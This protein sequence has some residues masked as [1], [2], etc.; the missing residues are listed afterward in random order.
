MRTLAVIDHKLTPRIVQ[1]KSKGNCTYS[2]IR[3]KKLIVKTKWTM[4]GIIDTVTSIVPASLKPFSKSH[5][6][7]SSHP[8]PAS[9]DEPI[10]L[11][12][13]LDNTAAQDQSSSSTWKTS[14]VAAFFAKGTG[15]IGQ[16]M[17]NHIIEELDKAG[18][19]AN[20]PSGPEDA[21][22]RV[23]ARVLPFFRE[24]LEGRSV[25]MRLRRSAT[26]GSDEGPAVCEHT[27]GPSDNDGVSRDE[28]SLQGAFD[29]GAIA[30]AKC[31]GGVN[32]VPSYTTFAAPE[33]WA[34]ISDIDDTI[35]VTL[36]DHV[37]GALKTTF[38]DDPTPIKG[39]PE[40]YWHMNTALNNPPFWYLSA[41]PYNLYPFLHDFRDKHYPRGT[42]ELRNASW[43][44]VL[45]FI[46]SVSRG[47][48]EYKIG[49]MEE[50]IFKYWPKRRF[51][52]LGDSTQSDPE[53]YGEM[54]R[55]HPGWIG[56]VF[57]RRVKDVVEPGDG[58]LPGRSDEERNKSER[59]EKA[60]E[61]VSKD[62]W[63][64][65]DEPEEVRERIDRLV[66]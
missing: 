58:V 35:K 29:D 46:E 22:K 10:D 38:L 53:V 65:F 32:H 20:K 4:S 59:F 49:K 6:P 41:S 15:M 42:L 26:A 16:P 33:G 13:L 8:K 43:Q 62:V 60:F 36:T 34:V 21:R 54:C 64:V 50:R 37:S 17:V 1:L 12:W 5:S 11:V 52:C 28:V 9:P 14:F 57:I 39:M 56:A 66:K 48:R 23:E 44:N 40:L 7:F 24:V 45:H 30:H 18:L 61:G 2:V 25:D 19:L 55:R 47:T 31:A 3:L 51:V 63:Y 27:I